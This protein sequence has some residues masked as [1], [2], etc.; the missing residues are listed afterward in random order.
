M[1][2]GRKQSAR[3]LHL[4]STVP[5]VQQQIGAVGRALPLRNDINTCLIKLRQFGEL[6]AQVASCVGLFISQDEPQVGP[7]IAPQVSAP[8]TMNAQRRKS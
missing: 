8:A 4:A 3:T 6:L 2:L 5:H 1:Y 7:S